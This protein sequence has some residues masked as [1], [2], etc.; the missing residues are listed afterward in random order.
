MRIIFIASLSHS[1]STL[2]DLLLNAHP[3]VASVGELKQLSRFAG[4]QK[5][6]V[7]HGCTCGAATLWDCP[8]WSRVSASAEEATGKTIEEL[9][10]ENYADVEA[11]PFRGIMSRFLTR[12]RRRPARRAFVDSSKSRFRIKIADGQSIT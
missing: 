9:N 1:G 12:S 2:L 8:F 4:F 7:W 6:R 11:D 5:R 10:V 3:Q